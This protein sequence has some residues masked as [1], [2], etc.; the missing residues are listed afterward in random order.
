LIE[1]GYYVSPNGGRDVPLE[2][3]RK[4]Y[5]ALVTNVLSERVFASIEEARIYVRGLELRLEQE[6]RSAQRIIAAVPEGGR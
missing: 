2:E 6:P 1:Q 3:I 4:A 5:L